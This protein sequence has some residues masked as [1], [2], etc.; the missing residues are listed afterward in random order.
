MKTAIIIGAG[1]AGL[2]AAYELSRLSR[3]W[4]IVVL[5]GTSEIGGIS[6]TAKCGDCRIDIGGHRFF[7]KSKEVNDLWSSLMP[8]QGSPA[9]DDLLLGRKCRL[10][11]GGPDPEQD[12]RVM[13]HRRR[14]SRIYY[15]RHFF[16]YPISVKPAT[17]LAMGLAR[18]WKA[19]WS[20]LHSVFVK[21]PE[22][23]LEDFYINRFGRVLYS[24]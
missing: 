13:L 2:T 7:S 12:E 22:K 11:P 9:K 23:S 18:T 4:R 5:E 21:R 14:V 19:G 16:D 24:I 17:F 1:P 6:R 15:L 20:Y 3:E 8:L 10:E